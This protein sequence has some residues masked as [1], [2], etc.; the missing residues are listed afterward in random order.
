MQQEGTNN[1]AGSAKENE[2]LRKI[3]RLEAKYANTDVRD[4][5]ER[6]AT[7]ELI[8]NLKVELEN[9]RKQNHIYIP[10]NLDID[11]LKDECDE[12]VHKLGYLSQKIKEE[13][14]T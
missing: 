13:K 2:L 8:V 1:Y 7:R 14:S 6:K 11:Q 12:L 4:Y 5:L 3:A 10:I 9:E